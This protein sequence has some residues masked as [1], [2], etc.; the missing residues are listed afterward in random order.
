MSDRFP[1]RRA[2][3]A[4]MTLTAGALA[5]SCAAS[6]ADWTKADLMEPSTLAARL[7]QGG[8]KPLTIHVGFH[9]LYRT[10][11]IPGTPYAGPGNRADGM[12]ALR[13]LVAN[14]PRDREIVIYCGCCPW[15]H[16]PNMQPAFALLKKMGFK[17]VKALRIENNFNQDWVAKG[18]PSESQMGL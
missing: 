12:A 8:R 11:H 7:K 13:K 2:L 18:Y 5:I 17:R 4:L 6:A 16:C 10:R 1:I 15:S 9:M 14:E 3:L